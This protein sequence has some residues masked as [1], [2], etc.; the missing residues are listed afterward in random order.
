M[1]ILQN[2][3][4]VR[5]TGLTVPFGVSGGTAPYTWSVA[6]GGVG[7]TINSSTGIYLS[8]INVEGTDTIVVTDSASPTATASTA[9]AVGWPI[10]LVIDIIRSQLGLA[11]DQIWLYNQKEFISPDMRTYVTVGISHWEF[12][13]TSSAT[14]GSG[15][16][17]SA[18]GGVT[19]AATLTLDIQSRA[20]RVLHEVIR[21]QAALKSTYAEQQMELNGF[22][23]APLPSGPIPNIGAID[24]A[25]IPWHFRT[26]AV[27]QWADNAQ[28]NVP[29][30]DT[31]GA[32]DI[33]EN[34]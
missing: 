29:F 33:I 13:G 15:S 9:I 7:G 27:L 26:Q 20:P 16:T 28:T 14:N 6:P 19:V 8:P 2:V 12:F 5:N 10:N 31:F 22:F 25:A 34:D 18:N 24:G 3:N 32:P 17:L 4:A 21:M 1:Q 30:Y 23:V 11:T